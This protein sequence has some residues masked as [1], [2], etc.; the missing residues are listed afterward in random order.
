MI[1]NKILPYLD[2]D[3]KSI[4][5][6]PT[7]YHRLLMT[8]LL[9]EKKYITNKSFMSINN[10]MNT[11]LDEE[12]N[13][14]EESAIIRKLQLHQ[15]LILD[16]H[17]YAS[18]INFINELYKLENEI[19]YSNID[20]NIQDNEYLKYLNIKKISFNNLD[21][22]FDEVIILSEE[23]FY[24]I[25][26]QF[27]EKISTKVNVINLDNLNNDIKT[28]INYYEL[29]NNQRMLDALIWD[30]YSNKRK[31][32][33]IC[34]NDLLVTSLT[35]KLNNV[36]ITTYYNKPTITNE[37]LLLL[38]EFETYYHYCDLSYQEL[39][40]KLYQ[41]LVK[42]NIFDLE[43][44]NKLFSN[45]YH[46]H[47]INNKLLLNLLKLELAYNLKEKDMNYDADI[48]IASNDFI[49]LKFENVWILDGSLKSLNA[50]KTSF[51]I[52]TEERIKINEKLITNIDYYHEYT[53][54]IT[55]LKTIANNLNIYY[56]LLGFDNKSQKLHF[57]FQV[58]E[59][60]SNIIISDSDI[61][62]YHL[63]NHQEKENYLLKDN[64]V[65]KLDKELLFNKID[66]QINIFATS[67]K[68]YD[69][70][71]YKYFLNY[72]IGFNHDNEFNAMS[73]GSYVH[74]AIEA[75]NL[76]I[77]NH[78]MVFY[79]EN[80][81]LD[82]AL[83]YFNEQKEKLITTFNLD[84][85]VLIQDL[86]KQFERYLNK[87]VYLKYRLM[88]ETPYQESE[89]QELKIEEPYE[90]N[91]SLN[92]MIKGK[93]DSVFTNNNNNLIVDYKTGSE[94]ENNFQL[95][96]YKLLLNTKYPLKNFNT[97]IFCSLK[98]K[99]YDLK[100]IDLDDA[101]YFNS[102]FQG[103]SDE[104]IIKDN[105]D[106]FKLKRITALTKYK[107]VNDI[108]KSIDN[109]LNSYNNA[110]FEIAPLKDACTFCEYK[111]YLCKYS[112]NKNKEEGE[113]DE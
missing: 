113:D 59:D 50:F 7:K 98:P 97:G 40:K 82:I 79:E 2:N 37:Y 33:I 35:N 63:D 58:P 72:L 69:D 110:L 25:H 13:Y 65:I 74:E 54:H 9:K 68:D 60:E 3:K 85:P 88:K 11:C 44:L 67:L 90:N 91:L 109:L 95:L 39:L 47:N 27:I 48:I 6:L 70:C 93:I 81:L 78:N 107:D 99:Y 112:I 101:R 62:F 19:R 61:N 8:K 41:N 5:I 46:L 34:D 76:M 64:K 36:G 20:F 56:S 84:N 100:D 86:N 43:Y 28:K 53:K 18:N 55:K 51:L 21:I 80:K 22:T 12:D 52:T 45:I 103:F 4:F 73:I 57:D 89:M 17:Q 49:S 96:F 108:K 106:L 32:L 23:E 94:P 16:F 38:K 83:P 14:D 105:K 111:Q 30:I 24:P 26:H 71:P 31:G 42:L 66:Y 15:K 75:T 29:N 10:F 87:F 77:T 1:I 104:K 102:K 92:T